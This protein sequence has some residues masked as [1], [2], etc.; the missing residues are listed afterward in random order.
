MSLRTISIIG[1]ITITF[2]VF[3]QSRLTPQQL[4]DE[5][6]QEIITRQEEAADTSALFDKYPMYPGGISGVLNH[7][8]KN[9]VY[10]RKAYFKG[11]QG[12]VVLKF[13]VEKDGTA[14]V[15][16]ITQ[17]ATPEMDKEAIR[18]VKKLELFEPAYKDGEPIECFFSLPVVFRLPQEAPTRPASVRPLPDKSTQ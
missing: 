5:N 14:K 9:L 11:L 17:S 2:S 1:L 4:I 12:R 13:S 18:V 6:Y 3:G 10:P 15:V 16:E 8:S 7:I